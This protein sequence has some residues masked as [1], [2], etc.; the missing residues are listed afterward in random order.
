MRNCIA[1]RIISVRVCMGLLLFLQM[2]RSDMFPGEK[3]DMGLFGRVK[4]HDNIRA[5]ERGIAKQ[6]LC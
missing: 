2:V 4:T 3:Y 1:N 5:I 6:P